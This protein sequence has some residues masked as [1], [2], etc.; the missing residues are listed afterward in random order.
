MRCQVGRWR[1]RLAQGVH[2]MYITF[3]AY[4]LIVRRID[5]HAATHIAHRAISTDRVRRAGYSGKGKD[6]GR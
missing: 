2:Y 4:N 6:F 3:S 5:H 1:G